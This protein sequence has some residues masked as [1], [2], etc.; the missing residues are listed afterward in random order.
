M[1]ALAL[2][3]FMIRRWWIGLEADIADK[4]QLSLAEALVSAKAGRN[5]RW[6]N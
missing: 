5:E 2:Y 3:V 1:R 4:D 6:T